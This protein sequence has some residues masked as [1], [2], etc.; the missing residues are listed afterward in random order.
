LY[1][2]VEIERSNTMVEKSSRSTKKEMM[3]LKCRGY[4]RAIP[5]EN[6]K[7]CE[8]PMPQFVEAGKAMEGYEAVGSITLPPTTRE[9]LVRPKESSDSNV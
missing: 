2:I 1:R 3:C 6:I 7:V 4:Q 9:K 5:G 8:C